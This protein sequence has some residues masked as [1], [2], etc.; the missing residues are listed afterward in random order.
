MWRN[1]LN[2]NQ[3]SYKSWKVGELRKAQT[4]DNMTP[5]TDDDIV[6]KNWKTDCAKGPT[7]LKVMIKSKA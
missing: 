3:T 6:I 2:Y 4:P 7:I 1:P 5:I